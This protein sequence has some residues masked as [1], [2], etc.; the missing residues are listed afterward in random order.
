MIVTSSGQ[1][2]LLDTLRLVETPEGIALELRVAGPVVRALAWA[3]DSLLKYGILWVCFIA[4]TTLG[5]TG[6]G[7]WLIAIFVLEWFYPVAFE[8]YGDGATPGKKMLK[9]KVVSDNGAPVDFS[10]SL[11]RNLLRTADFMPLFY[12]FGL[13]CM[14]LNRNFKRLGDLAASTIVIYR[15]GAVAP[16]ELPPGPAQPLPVALPA[17]E[18]QLL[19]NFAER[20]HYLNPQRQAELADLLQ[21]LTGKTGAGA[22]AQLLANARWLLGS[23]S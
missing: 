10:A 17:S 6:Y 19:I 20:S 18:Q 21:V 23:K 1:T 22:A 3:V 7:L 15:D 2:D 12:G 14:L 11:I 13:I 8:V 5:A 4:L 16:P 9:L